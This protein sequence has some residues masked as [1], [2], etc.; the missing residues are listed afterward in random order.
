MDMDAAEAGFT[1]LGEAAE[2]SMDLVGAALDAIPGVGEV[3]LAAEV[4]ICFAMH[5]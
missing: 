3:L 2:F 1:A 5:A 4:R